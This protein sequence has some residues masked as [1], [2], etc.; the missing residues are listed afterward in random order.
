[1]DLL[2][3]IEETLVSFRVRAQQS[4]TPLLYEPPD[5]PGLT[6]DL[7][8]EA[9]SQALF[10]LLDNALKYSPAGL[11]VELTVERQGREV[12]VAVRDRGIGIPADEHAKVF[13]RFHRVGSSLVHDVKGS[14]LGLSIAKHIVEAH[15]GRLTLESAPGQGSL[16]RLHLPAL[17]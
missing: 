5:S 11:P 7:D 8:P 1:M 14:G 3:V 9:F 10:N 15:G 16:F 13:E 2:P 12:V 17:G 6:V 4:G